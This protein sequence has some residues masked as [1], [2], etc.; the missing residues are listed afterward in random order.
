MRRREFISLLGGAA[1]ALGLPLPLRAQQGDRIRRIAWFGL[2]RADAPSPYVDALRSGLRDF[3]WIEG[4]N[5]AISLYWATGRQDMDA[6]ARELV[7]SSPEVIIAQELMVYAVQP[8]KPASPVV[9]GFSGDPVEGKLVESYPRPGGNFTGMTYLAIELVGKRIEVLK[10]WVPQFR[11]IAVLARPQHPGEHKE[12]QATAEVAGKLG[13][14][15]SYFPIQDLAELDE[16]FR[17]IVQSRCDALV[18]FPDTTMFSV[19]DRIARFASEAMLPSVSGWAPFAENGLLLTYG[20][21]IRDLYRS[22]ARYADRIL[23]G[24]KPADLPVEL[25][26]KFETVINLRTAKVLGL[27]VPTSILL[28]ADKV[29]E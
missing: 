27:D 23:R 2:G 29:I 20:P 8:L 5:L 13:I 25:P 1:A 21:N 22:L 7:A 12:R 24:A 4:R 9:F 19:S 28:R 10:E 26:T 3:G 15:F 18:V 16:A 17:A 11:R 14:E 6:V